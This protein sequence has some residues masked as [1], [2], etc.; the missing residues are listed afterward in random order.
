MHGSQWCKNQDK[1]MGKLPVCAIIVNLTAPDFQIFLGDT[2]D[3][4]A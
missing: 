4:L 3:P 1:D 2:P